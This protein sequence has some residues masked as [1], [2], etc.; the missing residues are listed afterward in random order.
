MGSRVQVKRAAPN[1]LHIDR[2]PAATRHAFLESVRDRLFATAGWYLAGGTAL[3]LQVGHRES[4][5]LDFFTPRKNFHEPQFE[6]KLMLD[7]KWRTDF[8][9]E[10]TL[11]GRYRDAKMSFIAYPFFNPSS[12]LQCGSLQMVMPRDIAAMKIEA[13]SQRGK[14]RDFV[15]LYWYGRN[16]EPIE[17]AILRSF[18]QYVGENR[19]LTHI[20]KSLTYFTDAEKDPMPKLFFEADWQT[21]KGYFLREVPRMARKLLF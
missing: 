12:F 2:L 10:G 5:E 3:A 14:K 9:A 6:K 8:L 7:G 15:D 16:I 17:N 20:I 19:N 13:I 21:I 18:N 11:Y 1:D 4:E